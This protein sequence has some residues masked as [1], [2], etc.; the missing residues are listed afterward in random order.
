MKTG[1]ASLLDR[2]CSLDVHEVLIESPVA[3]AAAARRSNHTTT[4]VNARNV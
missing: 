4:D 1:A 2:L 3:E